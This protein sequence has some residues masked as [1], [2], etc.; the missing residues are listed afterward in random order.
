MEDQRRE[1]QPPLDERQ[2]FARAV[3]QEHRPLKGL[4]PVEQTGVG[5]QVHCHVQTQGHN[6]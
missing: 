4:G 5:R 6:A 3:D 2:Q 1:N